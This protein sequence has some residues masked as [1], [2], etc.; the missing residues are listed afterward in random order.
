VRRRGDEHVGEP[1]AVDVAG[2]GELGA[3]MIPA[4]IAV[5]RDEGRTRSVHAAA[6][7][8]MYPES[9]S[10][11]KSHSGSPV[12]SEAYPERSIPG[13][14]ATASPRRVPGSFAATGQFG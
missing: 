2:V 5:L 9:K 12:M 14:I 3:E 13:E 11:P 4:D 6:R 8:W 1:V 10:N 7:S